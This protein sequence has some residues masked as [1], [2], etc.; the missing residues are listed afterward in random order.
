MKPKEIQTV[1]LMYL[2]IEYHRRTWGSP[3]TSSWDYSNDKERNV[4]RVWDI[5]NVEHQCYDEELRVLE[6]CARNGAID[7]I[8]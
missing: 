4:W 1:A 5:L 7:E 8:H 6:Y 2:F 3:N